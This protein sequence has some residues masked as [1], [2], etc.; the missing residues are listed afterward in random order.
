M[1]W[2]AGEN[3]ALPRNCKRPEARASDSD[4]SLWEHGKAKRDLNVA[5]QETGANRQRQQPF[6]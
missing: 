2:E 5:S 3:P 4:W 6:A 1:S